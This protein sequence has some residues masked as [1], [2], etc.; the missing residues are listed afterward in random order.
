MIDIVLNQKK[1]QNTSKRKKNTYCLVCGKKT[2]NKNI[3]GVTLEN[4]TGQQIST[5]VDYGSRKSTF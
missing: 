4:K 3:K 5:C 1:N 2:G